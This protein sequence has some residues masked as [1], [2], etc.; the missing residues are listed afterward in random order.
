MSNPIA[1]LVSE[2]KKHNDSEAA[3]QRIR[4]WMKSSGANSEEMEYALGVVRAAMGLHLHSGS[5]GRVDNRCKFCGKPSDDVGTI[6]VSGEDSICDDCVLLA[7]HTLSQRPSGW[8]FRVLLMLMRILGIVSQSRP[9][10]LA[11]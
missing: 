2:T 11:R 7:L 6:L 8:R 10:T 1:D 3:V 4:E 9:S 5:G